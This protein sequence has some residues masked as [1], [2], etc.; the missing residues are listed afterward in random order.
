MGKKWGTATSV[1]DM[2]TLKQTEITRSSSILHVLI[3]ILSRS[4]CSNSHTCEKMHIVS[5][6][7]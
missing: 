5:L 1:E 7:N 3:E 6:I 2:D 4:F